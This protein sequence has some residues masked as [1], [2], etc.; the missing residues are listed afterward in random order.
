[1]AN[2]LNS[3][4]SVKNEYSFYFETNPVVIRPV[5][6]LS[7]DYFKNAKLAKA[8]EN[9]KKAIRENIPKNELLGL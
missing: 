8:G 3:D 6:Y 1:M 2:E 7:V 5:M 4:G 9:V